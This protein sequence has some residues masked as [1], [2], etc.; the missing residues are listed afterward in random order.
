MITDS[1]NAPDTAQDFEIN[2]RWW[3]VERTL[4]WRGALPQNGKGLEKSLGSAEL[5][6]LIARIQARSP[7]YWQRLKSCE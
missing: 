2:P 6:L 7:A 1:Q 5:R 3:V 4:A